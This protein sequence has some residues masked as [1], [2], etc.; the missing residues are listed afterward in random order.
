MKHVQK[1]FGRNLMW[2]A[3]VILDGFWILTIFKEMVVWEISRTWYIRIWQTDWRKVTYFTGCAATAGFDRIYSWQRKIE[4]LPKQEFWCCVF[5]FCHAKWFDSTV[6]R[7]KGKRF[8][9][10]PGR[11]KSMC[12]QMWNRLDGKRIWCA[13]LTDYESEKSNGFW[14]HILSN[15][16][17]RNMQ[18]CPLKQSTI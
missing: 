17:G 14:D 6:D 4:C 10:L 2:K 15:M 8:I 5:K 18:V 13:S 3:H 16:G 1:V 7:N 9:F 12:W 11:T